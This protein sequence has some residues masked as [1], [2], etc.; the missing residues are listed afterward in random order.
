MTEKSMRENN[1]S[2]LECVVDLNGVAR[3]TLNRPEVHHAFNEE[4]I[5]ELK[6]CFL[7]L[8]SQVGVRV[9]VLSS[10]GRVF[11]AGADMNW[12]KR[13]SANDADATFEDATKFAAMMQALHGCS[14]P[15]V[16]R[17]QGGTFG[18]GIGLICACDIVIASEQV[19]LAVSEA[20]FGTIPAVTCPISLRWFGFGRQCVLRSPHH[21]SVQ[22]KQKKLGWFI[23]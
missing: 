1:F 11:C 6:R 16:A 2:T 9:I 15:I 17:V 10:P 21:Q 7:Y 14:K 18:V 19:L 12:M 4:M 5:D 8:E 3:V 13:A 20:R 23:M 22:L